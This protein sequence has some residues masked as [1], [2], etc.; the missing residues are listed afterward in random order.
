MNACEW[1]E[2]DKPECTNTATNTILVD[3]CDE[4]ETPVCNACKP[5]AQAES[6]KSHKALEGGNPWMQGDKYEYEY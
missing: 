1:I 3:W 5:A 6:D 2:R 4:S